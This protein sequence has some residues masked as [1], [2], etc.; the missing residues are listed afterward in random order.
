MKKIGVILLIGLI[1][2]TMVAC[3]KQ[4]NVGDAEEQKPVQEIVKNPSVPLPVR[5][6]QLKDGDGN[7]LLIDITEVSVIDIDDN[8]RDRIESENKSR[9]NI[10]LPI[11]IINSLKKDYQ[12]IRV[13]GTIN[14]LKY[15]AIEAHAL[16]SQ[17]KLYVGD[18]QVEQ[19]GRPFYVD[20]NRSKETGVSKDVIVLIVRKE[21]IETNLL[22][23]Q[24][25]RYIDGERSK[26]YVDVVKE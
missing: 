15:S 18:M 22:Q 6:Q 20:W 19:L 17:F 16:D 4:E 11:D 8:L 23:L 7:E 9:Y 26:V 2:I 21:D 14:S 25:Q 3:K 1:C 12:A 24:V 5:Y 10:I 13:E